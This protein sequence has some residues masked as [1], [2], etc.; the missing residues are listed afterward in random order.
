M[1]TSLSR[2]VTLK[3]LK[4]RTRVSGKSHQMIVAMIWHRKKNLKIL[5]NVSVKRS[6]RNGKLSR[7]L[8]KVNQRLKLLNLLRLRKNS[9][10]GTMGLAITNSTMYSLP[11][12]YMELLYVR[13][14]SEL[15]LYINSFATRSRDVGICYSP[16]LIRKTS[17][18]PSRENLSVFLTRYCARPQ[19]E[20]YVSSR[21]LKLA[22]RE[23]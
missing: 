8:L 17:E 23:A 11:L 10:H 18:K 1:R 13:L 4:I 12:F 14:L 15:T 2:N 19:V 7:F 5:V 3:I 16:G 9:Q 20:I 22:R 6:K 21:I